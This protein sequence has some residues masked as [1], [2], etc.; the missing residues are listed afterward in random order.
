MSNLLN[1]LILEFQSREERGFKKYGTTMDRTDLSLSEWVQHALEE[2]MDLTQYLYKIK[3]QLNDTQRFPDYQ[4]ADSR[5][6]E[7]INTGGE[8][9]DTRTAL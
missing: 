9:S 7:S 6:S 2:A 8:A 3:Q 5:I 1:Q 4:E